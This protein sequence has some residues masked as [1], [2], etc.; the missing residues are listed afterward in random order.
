MKKNITNR[1]SK[2]FEHEDTD[3]EEIKEK[4]LFKKNQYI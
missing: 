4:L 3:K 1:M 2:L